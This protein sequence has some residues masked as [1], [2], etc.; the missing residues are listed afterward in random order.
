MPGSSDTKTTIMTAWD[1]CYNITESGTTT[2]F[3]LPFKIETGG[4]GGRLPDKLTLIE[5]TL[6]VFIIAIPSL[7]LSFNDTSAARL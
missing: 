1:D 2:H 6:L 5:T 3:D 7:K 4:G